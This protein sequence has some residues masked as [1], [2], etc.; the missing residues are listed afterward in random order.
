MIRLHSIALSGKALKNIQSYKMYCIHFIFS[1]FQ[2]TINKFYKTY[3]H[4]KAAA[5]S[6]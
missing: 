4:Q 6:M 1:G 3:P 2:F 5:I